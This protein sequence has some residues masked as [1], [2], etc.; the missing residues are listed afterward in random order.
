MLVLRS[1]INWLILNGAG[2]QRT[3]NEIIYLRPYAGEIS[4]DGLIF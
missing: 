3:I 1:V 4:D 2:K